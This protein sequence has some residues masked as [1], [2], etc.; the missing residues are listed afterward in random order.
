MFGKSRAEIDE[1]YAEPTLV[2]K[3]LAISEA[4]DE[5][6]SKKYSAQMISSYNGEERREVINSLP[7]LLALKEAFPQ[8]EI[9]YAEE[10]ERLWWDKQ[11]VAKMK[12]FK[13]DLW[14]NQKA[15][16]DVQNRAAV[17]PEFL[18]DKR[19]TAE[20]LERLDSAV[21]KAAYSR[22]QQQKATSSQIKAE[23]ERVAR[24]SREKK[25]RIS[26]AKTAWRELTKE[27]RNMALQSPSRATTLSR[28]NQFNPNYDWVTNYALLGVILNSSELDVVG[29]HGNADKIGLIV[30]DNPNYNP[31]TFAPS[32]EPTSHITHHTSPDYGS[33]SSYDS[34]SSYSGGEH[35][36]SSYDTG[37]SYSSGYDSGSS[38]SYD[39]GSSFDSGGGGSDGGGGF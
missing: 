30:N 21:Q 38:P 15:K 31:Y 14:Q 27:Q 6:T 36:H 13:F 24:E 5:L 9:D 16:E 37:S 39:S 28:L 3:Q 8:V 4:F 23:R 35:H 33:S 19:P 32:P 10:I 12:S 20:L 11:T 18:R 29:S 2:D 7:Q 22:S 26:S 17:L 25:E 1:S 34:G